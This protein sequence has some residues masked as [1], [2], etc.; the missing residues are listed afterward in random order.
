MGHTPYGYRIVNGKAVLDD[1]AAARVESLFKYYCSGDSMKTAAQK[2]GLNASHSTLRGMLQNRYYT[3]D[4]YY[5]A[6]ISYSTFETAA[7]ERKRRAEKLGRVYEPK[8]ADKV[9]PPTSF[10]IKE[11]VEQHADPYKQAEYIYSLIEVEG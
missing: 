11:V 10:R 5:P 3:G 8:L 6:I 1:V 9:L 4:D 7:Q 2:S